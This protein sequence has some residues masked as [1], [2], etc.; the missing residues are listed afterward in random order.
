MADNTIRKHPASHL[1]EHAFKPGQSGNPKGRPK[2]AR[3]KLGEEFLTD[4][5]E[6]WQERGRDILSRVAKENP[7]A[8]LKTVAHLIPREMMLT[9]H[10]QS[11]QITE[12]RH[13]IVEAGSRSGLKAD[14]ENT[15][16]GTAEDR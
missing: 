9:M 14:L 8:Y 13:V 2:G 3:N 1:V 12:V 16:E 15:Q 6:S 5:Y 10:N 7:V 11:Q 4:L